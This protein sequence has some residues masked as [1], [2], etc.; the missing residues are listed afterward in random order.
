MTVAQPRAYSQG[1]VS[2][3]A[4][5][6]FGCGQKLVGDLGHGAD[7]DHRPL[8]TGQ[9]AC[10]NFGGAKDRGGIFDRSAA[11]LHDHRL[12][13]DTATGSWAPPGAPGFTPGGT[14][15]PCAARNSPFNTAAPAPPRIVLC[16]STV[17]FQSNSEQGR[18][19]P[20]VA[21]IP[22]PRIRSSRGCGRSSA[23]LNS[24]GCKGAVGSVY[25]ANGAN[26]FQ[27]ARISSRVARAVSLM[28]TLSVWPSSTATRLQWALTLAFSASTLVPFSLPSSL[29]VSASSF[30]SSPLMWG[31]TLPRMSS[32]ATPG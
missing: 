19:R 25:P 18:K 7:H 14:S 17:N 29:R 3:P 4:P 21:A 1:S 5:G 26:S 24:T 30:S 22:L 32:E 16:E 23:A 9:P 12:H 10:D 20:T 27:A 11:K 8:A 13:A 2:I 6:S 28:L 31:T 15:L